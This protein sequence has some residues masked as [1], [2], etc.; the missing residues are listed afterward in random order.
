MEQCLTSS[1][2]ETHEGGRGGKF[3]LKLVFFPFSQGCVFSFHIAQDC[4][5]GK[6][7]TSR[8]ST[9]AC[10]FKL[11]VVVMLINCE[12]LAISKK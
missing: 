3:C 2:D 10:L 6:C 1:R 12:R 8:H 4:S 11:V 5:L 9:Q 7:L